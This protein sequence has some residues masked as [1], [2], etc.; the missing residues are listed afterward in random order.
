MDREFKLLNCEEKKEAKQII[1]EKEE[2]RVG[3]KT[4]RE[5]GR[6][7]KQS[8]ARKKELGSEKGKEE[9]HQE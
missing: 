1:R 6:T 9:D 2:V 7:R 8:V 5:R 4:S 3:R